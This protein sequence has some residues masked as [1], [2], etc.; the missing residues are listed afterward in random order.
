MC[1]TQPK[2]T[3][4]FYNKLHRCL[5]IATL[6]FK[7]WSEQKQDLELAQLKNNPVT[8]GSKLLEEA[9]DWQI[10]SIENHK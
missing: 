9:S 8:I 1:E 2:V 10:E 3:V 5:L 7:D 4:I 6:T